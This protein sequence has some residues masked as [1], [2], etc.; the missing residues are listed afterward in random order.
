MITHS[1][2]P[3][4]QR[5]LPGLPLK[6]VAAPYK[7]VF[8][9]GNPLKPFILLQMNPG[10]VLLCKRAR[11]GKQV[12]SDNDGGSSYFVLILS[13]KYQRS[14]SQPQFS[15]NRC[16]RTHLIIMIITGKVKHFMVQSPPGANR[17][18]S[19]LL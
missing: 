2:Q 6:Y 7:A 12:S 10:G 3:D 8:F 9:I 16:G 14:Q 13:P 11:Q 19:T 15:H 1:Q 17:R 18:F 4:M 5:F